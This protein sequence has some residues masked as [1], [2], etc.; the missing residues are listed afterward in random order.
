[1]GPCVSVEPF[2]G[3]E[4]IRED[5]VPDVS[6]NTGRGSD[7]GLYVTLLIVSLGAALYNLDKIRNLKCKH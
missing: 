7:L 5:K 4:E 3:M 1:M 6:P 2:L